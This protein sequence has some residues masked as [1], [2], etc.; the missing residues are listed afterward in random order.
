M[1]HSTEEQFIII[2][3]VKEVDQG[4]LIP[5]DAKLF[6]HPKMVEHTD[7]A[8]SDH[9]DCKIHITG[10]QTEHKSSDSQASMPRYCGISSFSVALPPHIV[11]TIKEWYIR[12]Q[13]K[14][15][16]HKT[17]SD[18][19]IA[20]KQEVLEIHSAFWKILPS[21]LLPETCYLIPSILWHKNASDPNKKL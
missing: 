6:Q 9:T 10:R 18:E 3:Q 20:S 15:K 13:F 1:D 19:W 11:R 4:N 21:I 8:I 7:H 12:Y 14:S 5:S 2:E 16:W 17:S